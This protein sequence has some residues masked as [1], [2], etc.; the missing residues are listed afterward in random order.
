M[1][2]VRLPV[3]PEGHGRGFTGLRRRAQRRIAILPGACANPD[4]PAR[5]APPMLQRLYD[6]TMRLAASRH[7]LWALVAIAFIESSFFPIPP[8]VLL[9][10]MMLAARRD[11]WRLR[12]GRDPRLGRGR[13]SRLY[14]RLLRLRRHRPADPRVLRRH[15]Q[16]RRAEG[17]LRPMGRVDHRL[18][19]HDADPLQ[20]LT[21]ASG[22]LDFNLLDLH[23]WRR[24]SRARC[25][26]S[27]WR[28]C[29][30]GSASRSERSSSAA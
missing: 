4:G 1:S 8:D 14:H 2:P 29:C 6:W 25:A 12:R 23:R 13:L 19:G 3:P 22:A 24:W 16:I 11:A 10:P 21:I 9:I 17:I 27:W 28:R 18:Q 7:A 20:A 30:G 15:G 5:P 26:S